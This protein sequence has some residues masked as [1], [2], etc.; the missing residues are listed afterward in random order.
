MVY[1]KRRFDATM[2][3]YIV[4]NLP[5]Y[6]R[7]GDYDEILEELKHSI[8]VKE[9]PSQQSHLLHDEVQRM[10]AKYLLGDAVDPSKELK[11]LLYG[12]I[13]D[14]YYPQAIATS[15]ADLA[16]Q[17]QSERLGYILDKNP[18]AGLQE[19]ETYRREIENTY[20][21]D[22][23]ELLW[24]EVREHLDLFE[25]RQRR[26]RICADRGQWLRRHS[27]F[28]KAEEHYRQMIGQLDE[29]PVETR[30]V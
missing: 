23:E 29:R 24:G 17:L 8:Y 3:K 5:E 27:L 16:C 25:E 14:R 18:D 9:H 4:E 7:P 20:D 15:D 6:L 11:N 21:Y 12:L 22:F 26:Y 2:L 30:L 1:L 19:Y 28:Q 10:V 13:I